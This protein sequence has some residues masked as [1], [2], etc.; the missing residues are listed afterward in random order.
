MGGDLW[1]VIDK[2]DYLEDLGIDGIYF[3]P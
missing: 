1:G 3:C 2:L